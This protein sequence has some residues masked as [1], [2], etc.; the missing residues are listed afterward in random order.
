[1]NS[2]GS[3]RFGSN[4]DIAALLKTNDISA[5]VQQHL[6]KVYS[7]LAAT[8]FAAAIGVALDIYVNLAGLLSVFLSIGLTVYLITVD[9]SL[10][11]KRL[12]L[13]LAIATCNGVNIGPLVSVALEVDPAIVVTAL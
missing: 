13:L 10:V 9:K 3:F 2:F 6:V 4:W 12:S 7:T 11:T 8:L 1:M 5:S